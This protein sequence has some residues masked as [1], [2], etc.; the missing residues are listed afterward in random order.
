VRRFAELS[1]LTVSKSIRTEEAAGRKVGRYRRRCC[2][3]S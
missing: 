1:A 2:S 3:P